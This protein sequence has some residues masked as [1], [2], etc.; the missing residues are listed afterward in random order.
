LTLPT[1][2]SYRSLASRR[3]LNRS[4]SLFEKEEKILHM[5]FLLRVNEFSLIRSVCCV[6]GMK[7]FLTQKT[8]F[9]FLFFFQNDEK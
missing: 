1:F 2:I 6:H 9:S 3:F 5:L 4:A 8:G 7:S